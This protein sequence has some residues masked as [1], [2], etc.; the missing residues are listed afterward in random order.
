M[1]SSLSLIWRIR[2]GV[3]LLIALFAVLSLASGYGMSRM[4]ASSRQLTQVEAAKVTHATRTL[5]LINDM[6][7]DIYALV[8]ENPTAADLRRFSTSLPKRDA[9]IRAEL[10]AVG[11]LVTRP[12]GKTLLGRLQTQHQALSAVTPQLV[13]LLQSGQEPEARD[14]FARQGV[15]VLH[16]YTTRMREFL[17]LQESL[18]RQAAEQ[19]EATSQQQRQLLWGLTLFSGL[20]ALGVGLGIL[21]SVQQPLGGDPRHAAQ[22]LASIAEGNLTHHIVAPQASPHSLMANL[23]RMRAQLHALVARIQQATGSV[24]GTASNMRSLCEHI[25]QGAAGQSDAT[26]AMATAVD[27]LGR[28]IERLS[29]SSHQV[30]AVSARAL[31]LSERGDQ[32][33]REAAGE[34]HRMVDTIHASSREVA[35]LAGKTDEIHRVVGVIRS[36]AEQTN[37]LAL[38]ASIEAARAGEAGRGFAVVADEIRKLSEHTTRSTQEIADT[39]TAIQQQTRASA[40]NLLQGEDLVAFGVKLIGEL[41]APFAELRQGAQS[42]HSELTRLIDALAEQNQAAQHIGQRTG[43]V[44]SSAATFSVNAHQ[45]ITLAQQLK[46]IVEQLDSE[47][48][49]FKLGGADSP[50]QCNALLA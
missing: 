3:I 44:A 14:L 50:H 33:L 34:I 7:R 25:H 27:Q 23:E 13:A 4:Q 46:S 19:V 43:Q 49:R 1:L 29:A 24:S 21:R 36:I 15:P 28:N 8:N 48:G 12:E 30:Q 42:A 20:A 5:F 32:L 26:A 35:E 41:L 22:A 18:L 9:A 6:E 31:T 40:N 2:L 17:A 45:A 38:N 39:I 47:V 16:D 11:Q 37:L 10:M